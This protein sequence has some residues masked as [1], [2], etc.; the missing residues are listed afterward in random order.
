MIQQFKKEE[1]KLIGNESEVKNQVKIQDKSYLSNI[2]KE[3]NKFQLPY[4]PDLTIYV[5]KDLARFLLK[6]N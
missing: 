2:K 5:K 4:Q 6:V 1:H 3:E